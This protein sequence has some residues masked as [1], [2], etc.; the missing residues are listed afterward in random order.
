MTELEIDWSFDVAVMRWSDGENRLRRSSVD[1]WNAALDELE[2]TDGP[3]AAVVVGEGKFFSNGLDLEWM[4]SVPEG[5]NFVRDV[6][7]LLGRLLIFPGYLVGALNGHTFA[8]GAMLSLALDTRVMRR[9][10]GFW[11]LPEADL[12]L[13]LT[14]SMA[15]C[16]TA[17]LPRITAHDAIVTGR[18]YTADE[19]L[20]AGIVEH[21][22]GE[23][24]VLSSAIELAT[25]MAHKDRATLH[26]HKKW[27]YGDAAAR[28]GVTS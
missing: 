21:V 5:R 4:G 17:K 28:C 20:A 14:D 18:R 11:C 3:V 13:P 27:L 19:A 25:A 9:D 7:L 16:V 24:D 6:H 10:R 15:A 26:S 8:A 2:A 22:A 23:S 12:G 1:A